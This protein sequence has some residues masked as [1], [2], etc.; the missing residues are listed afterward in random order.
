MPSSTRTQN[1]KQLQVKDSDSETSDEEYIDFIIEESSG[2]DDDTIGSDDTDTE[3]EEVVTKKRKYKRVKARRVDCGSGKMI[4]K[5]K[6][7]TWMKLRFVNKL[8]RYF[9]LDI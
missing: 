3:D 8:P 9:H 4:L 6:K 2:D 5:V 7:M 1:K